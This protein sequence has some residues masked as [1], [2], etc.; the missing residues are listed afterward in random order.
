MSILSYLRRFTKKNLLYTLL[1]LLGSL[2][3]VTGGIASAQ[4][5]TALVHTDFTKF[6]YWILVMLIAYLVSCGMIVVKAIY[7]SELI[8]LM[9]T[10]IRSDI[11]Q[12]ITK[13][14]YEKYQENDNSVYVAWLSSDIK[15][16][17]DSGFKNVYWIIAEVFDVLLSAGALLYFHVSLLLTTLMLVAVMILLPK[18]FTKH[19]QAMALN[20][21]HGNEALIGKLNDIMQGF[22]VFYSLNLGKVLQKRVVA[23]SETVATKNNAY[24][25]ISGLMRGTVNGISIISQVIILGQTGLLVLMKLVPIGAISASQYF[26]G[27]IFAS[28]TGI[29][30][31]W[32]EMKSVQAIFDKFQ[33]ETISQEPSTASVQPLQVS[34]ATHNL[35]FSYAQGGAN[36]LNNINLK[37]QRGGKY[38]LTGPSGAGKSTLLNIIAT[39]I[40]NYSGDVF[41][42]NTAYTNVALASIREQV[43][44]LNQVPYI[45]NETLQNNIV[46]DATVDQAKL[47]AVI[48]QAGLDELVNN[49]PAG[50]AAILAHGGTDISGGQRQK[51]A[52]ARGLYSGRTVILFDEG[53]SALDATQANAIEN[54]LVADAE[55][56]LVF[57]TH[58]LTAGLRDKL[59]AV[60]AMEKIN[61]N[62]AEEK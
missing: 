35:S 29:S 39:N 58:H 50:I 4:S 7:Q 19:L 61:A 3:Q 16:I 43:L 47:T 23:A 46:M 13:I 27:T 6:I 49:L 12:R 42:D 14:N 32:A 5:L 17:S 45:F 33:N 44:Y 24:E 26:A 62:A 15:T 28:L 25:Q 9:S 41:Y 52:L 20:L 54:L 21:S 11:A 31:D 55:L 2:A 1:I 22:G 59:D 8:Q 18:L 30:S 53:T 37:I 56:T 38:A 60:F 40:E 36:I 57:A 10:S 48:H 34:I 51:I